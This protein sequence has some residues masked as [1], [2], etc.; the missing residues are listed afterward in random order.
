MRLDNIDSIRISN[1]VD[2]IECSIERKK[3]IIN[4][5]KLNRGCAICGYNESATALDFHHIDRKNKKY[6]ISAMVREGFSMRE[7]LQEIEKCEVLCSNCHREI[8]WKKDKI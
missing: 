3:S 7:I 6:N 1:I 5:I 2:K 4:M 8:S